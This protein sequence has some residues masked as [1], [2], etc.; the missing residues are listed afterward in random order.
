MEG[1]RPADDTAPAHD[2]ARYGHPAPVTE[3]DTATGAGTASADVAAAATAASAADG[4]SATGTATGAAAASTVAAATGPGA[5]AGSGPATGSGAPAGSGA[6]TAPGAPAGAAPEPGGPARRVPHRDA[7]TPGTGPGAATEGASDGD[8]LT[9]TAA[10][11]APATSSAP[12]TGAAVADPAPASGTQGAPASGTQGAPAS[13]TQGAPAA[14][15][16]PASAL[17]DED[18]LG[19]AARTAPAV[20]GD[21]APDPAARTA[22]TPGGEVAPGPPPGPAA[23]GRGVL[24]WAVLALP[25]VTADRLGM[26]EPRPLWQQLAGLAVL[27]AAAALSR[28][29]PLASFALTA[30]LGLA[31]TPALFSVSYGPALGVFA[32]LL[33]LRAP[34]SRPAVAAFVAVALVGT[35]RIALVGVDPPPEWLVLTGTLLFGCVFPWLCGRYWRQSRAL[36]EAGWLK[37]ARLEDE[38]RHAEE[39]ARLRE[40]ARIAQDMHDSLGHELS[41]LALRAAALQV[42]PGLAT[43]H[44]AAAADLRAA[45]ADATDHLHRIIG[46]LREDDEPVPLAPAGESVRQLVARA[47]ESGLPV[48]WEEPSDTTA[49]EVPEPGGVTAHLLHRV[50]R[51]ALTNAARHAPGAPVVVAV[52]NHAHGTTV[53]VTNGPAT[54]EATATRGGSGLLGLRAAVTSVGGDLRAGPHG[55]GFRV[56]AYVPAQRSTTSARQPAGSPAGTLTAVTAPFTR[57]RRRVALGLGAA[58]GAGAVLVGAAFGWYAYTETHSVLTPAAYAKL[59]PGTP[60]DEVALVLPDREAHDPPTDRA[61]APPAG[62]H[63]RY[64]RASGELL[65]SIDHFRLCFDTPGRQ[66]RLISKDVV[67]GVGRPDPDREES[68]ENGGP[69]R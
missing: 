21:A 49:A 69:T 2:L 3:H 5:P 59:R 24:L 20:G 39:R 52:R 34:R 19:P 23:L 43:D 51:E 13:G 15:T 46:V 44:R 38:Q 67:P 17:G 32:V 64:Y 16:G 41:L 47:A 6:A 48:R 56:R 55:E 40:R 7:P 25:A 1:P 28:R 18:A 58:A 60:Y 11:P 36:A 33:G 22:P 61:P 53:T 27:A 10:G 26:N 45:A 12:A 63:C 14:G 50:V 65:V 68:T 8:A 31:A 57:A 29:Q 35:A 4:A 54:Q 42:S 66:G 37:A 62:A 9:G 30:A